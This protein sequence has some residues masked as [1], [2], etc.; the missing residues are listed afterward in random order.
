MS[1]NFNIAT[2][3]STGTDPA[4]LGMSARPV[5][6]PIADVLSRACRSSTVHALPVLSLVRELTS[7]LH[8]WRRRSTERDMLTCLT[9]RDLRDMG[10]SRYE[11][12]Q[13]ACK[14][15]WRA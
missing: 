14:P 7:T 1:T 2:P 9:E 12:A 13:E 10:I 6:L 3:A 5:R 4:A 15:F 8:T 11:A